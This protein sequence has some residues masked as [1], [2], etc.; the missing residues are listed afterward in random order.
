[1]RVECAY[2]LCKA[3][4]QLVGVLDSTPT[5]MQLLNCGEGGVAGGSRVEG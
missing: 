5:T 4:R 1:M 3:A 2:S